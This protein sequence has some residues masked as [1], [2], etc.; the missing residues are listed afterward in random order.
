MYEFQEV[1]VVLGSF[2]K[3]ARNMGVS[4][5]IVQRL[6]QEW[7]DCYQGP[8]TIEEALYNAGFSPSPRLLQTAQRLWE[9]RPFYRR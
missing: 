1:G 6:P 7:P 2:Q 4:M 3:K 9:Y 8:E 5:E